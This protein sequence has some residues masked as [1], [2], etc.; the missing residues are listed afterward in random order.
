MTGSPAFLTDHYEL[1]MVRAALRDGTAQHR[2][3]F[4]LFGRR[5][6][7]GRR[8]GAVAGIWRVLEEV[9]RF[10]FTEE[11]IDFAERT[12]IADDTTARWMADYRFSGDIWGYPDG[13]LWFP[14]SPLLTVESTF[15]EAVVLE[16]LLLSILNHDCAVAAAA[17][18][19]VLAARERPCVE[20]GSR[21]THEQAAVASAVAT[22]IA[23]FAST[24][25]LQAG[26]EHGIPTLGTAAHSYTLVHDSERA[27]FAAQV[28]ALGVNTTL[29]VDTFHT[30]QGIRTAIDVAGPGLGGIRLDS[31]DLVIEAQ[32]ARDL[33]DALGATGTRVVVTSDLDEFSVDELAGSPVDSYG[34]GTRVVTGSGAPTA[35]L[36]YKLVARAGEP[37]ADQALDPVAKLSTDKVSVGGRK[38]AYRRLDGE[39]VAEAEVLVI[40]D[41]GVPQPD[42]A[43][44]RPVLVP[45]VAQGRAVRPPD[46]AQSRRRHRAS[47]A[48]LPPTG[49]LISPGVPAIP[50][51]HQ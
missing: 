6:P 16:T 30:E 5:L 13:E 37:G 24:S 1:T 12:G 40:A 34:V 15:A 46:L 4:E 35:E 8:Y 20:M 10:R 42:P 9:P 41:E 32:R 22:Y 38:A 43:T 44:H 39:G 50:T 29:L 26:L 11:Q 7:P 14:F 47:V 33:L 45:L 19:I 18:R 27:A 2:S 23:G 31:G 17:S 3:V 28:E 48:E 49:R 21:R 51:E 36:V 25:N